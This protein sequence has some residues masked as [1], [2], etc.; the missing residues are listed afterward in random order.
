MF[1]Q[2]FIRVDADYRIT[3]V[4]SPESNTIRVRAIETE[5]LQT[6]EIQYRLINNNNQ[7]VGIY[8]LSNLQ[9]LNLK[10][11]INA[12]LLNEIYKA[13]GF[14]YEHGIELNLDLEILF[15]NEISEIKEL[16]SITTYNDL[17][18]RETIDYLNY[19]EALI[20]ETI[21]RKKLI[22][23]ALLTLK[24]STLWNAMDVITILAQ[25]AN[26]IDL[27]I[28]RNLKM[29]VPSNWLNS[30]MGST[31]FQMI[32]Y[33]LKL[34]DIP[35]RGFINLGYQPF[36]PD[37][38]KYFPNPKFTKDDASFTV[39][40][41]NASGNGVIF[42]RSQNQDLLAYDGSN[43]IV[44]I[45]GNDDEFAPILFPW[46]SSINGN[47]TIN[48]VNSSTIEIWKDGVNLHTAA[49]PSADFVELECYSSLGYGDYM[50]E[51][52]IA[53]YQMVYIGR[54]LTNNEIIKL[55]TF[56]DEYLAALPTD[57]LSGIT[58]IV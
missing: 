39:K 19:S 1:T 52:M 8:D 14:L 46:T 31:G 32:N 50:T 38:N 7:V 21:E 34:N 45:T 40:I 42:R 25:S 49:C 24:N 20:L 33:G 58:A 30:F 23:K 13:N 57:N 29:N 51:A 48:R 16:P 5:T 17:F 4:N 9:I 3:K 22:N 11:S 56:N 27:N 36:A 54:K 53:A 6:K 41:N 35:N 12:A 15:P 28:N 44:N 55:H 2:K 43:I 37:F 10:V 47:W 26:W 18:E